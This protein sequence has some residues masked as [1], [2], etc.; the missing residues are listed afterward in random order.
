MGDQ[1]EDTG[2]VKPKGFMPGEFLFALLFLGFAVF[3]LSQLG[4]EAKFSAKGKFFSQPAL[5]P[6][7]AVIGMTVFGITHLAGTL[8][9]RKVASELAEGEYWLRP[10]EYLG[11]FMAYVAATPIIGYLAATLLFMVI[12]CLR[13]GYRGARPLVAAGMVGLLIVLIFKTGLSVSIPG[14]AIYEYL[15]TDLR[16]FMLVNF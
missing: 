6:G 5:W 13:A 15:P 8:K 3:L 16:K 12:L 9:G 1:P 7:I 10:L 11:W 2:Q 4:D 14:G